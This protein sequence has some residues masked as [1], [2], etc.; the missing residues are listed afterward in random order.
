MARRPLSKTASP[1]H[2]IVLRKVI[3]PVFAGSHTKFLFEVLHK[4]ASALQAHHFADLVDAQERCLHQLS[5]LAK[6][7]GL[8]MPVWRGTKLSL[9]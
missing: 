1:L 8:E 9:E 7:D 2:P 6:L 3:Q 4:M 5:D